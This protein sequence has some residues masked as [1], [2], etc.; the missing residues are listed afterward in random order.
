M[1]ERSAM[2]TRCSSVL[3]S[4]LRVETLLYPDSAQILLHENA[5]HAPADAQQMFSPAGLEE[6]VRLVEIHRGE[7][8]VEPQ[9]GGTSAQGGQI[10]RASCRERGESAGI[11]EQG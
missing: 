1:V 7:R 9:R 10:G 2:S 4:D 11:A 6:P 3:T 8:R 5:G